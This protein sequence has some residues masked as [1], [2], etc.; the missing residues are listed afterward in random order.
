[1]HGSKSK[2]NMIIL[3]IIF[4][5]I[6]HIAYHMLH[7]S[8]LRHTKIL[9]SIKYAAV[10]K[11]SGPTKLIGSQWAET[12]FLWTFGHILAKTNATIAVNGSLEAYK[13]QGYN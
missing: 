12:L 8:L 3:Y 1:M 7:Q 13:Q 9:Y 6:F 2:H 5:S 10:T 11:R 4:I